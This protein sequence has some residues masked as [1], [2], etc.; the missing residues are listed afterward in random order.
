LEGKIAHFLMVVIPILFKSPSLR[1]PLMLFAPY[2]EDKILDLGDWLMTEV[3]PIGAP[4][5]T[6]RV[7]IE[8]TADEV[9]H[10]VA[11]VSNSSSRPGLATVF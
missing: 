10:K 5:P 11:F 6:C 9:P 8:V 4:N 2:I 1:T 3:I 7:D